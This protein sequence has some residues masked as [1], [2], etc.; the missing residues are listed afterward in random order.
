MI[1]YCYDCRDFIGCLFYYLKPL[2]TYLQLNNGK[3]EY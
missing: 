2:H 1:V 3:N